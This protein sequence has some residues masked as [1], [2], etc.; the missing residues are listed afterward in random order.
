[1]YVL[2]LERYEND[3]TIDEDMLIS[4]IENSEKEILEELKKLEVMIIQKIKSRNKKM[5][6]LE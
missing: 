2:F 6:I 3:H 4:F 1:M 5:F